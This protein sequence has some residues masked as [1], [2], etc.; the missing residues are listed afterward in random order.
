MN[1]SKGQYTY[2]LSRSQ[3]F[4]FFLLKLL[5]QSLLQDFILHI[6]CNSLLDTQILIHTY[7]FSFWWERLNYR[8]IDLEKGVFIALKFVK[9]NL[10]GSGFYVIFVHNKFLIPPFPSLLHIW[11]FSSIVHD[12]G[13]LLCLQEINLELCFE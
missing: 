13:M 4:I 12:R 8:R 9:L 7:I 3:W 11:N 10:K 6:Q 2:F 1:I 5:L